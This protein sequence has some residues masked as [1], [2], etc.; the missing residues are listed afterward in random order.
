VRNFTLSGGFEGSGAEVISWRLSHR[1]TAVPALG[2]DLDD[3]AL[4]L[5][6]LGGE[7]CIALFWRA[8]HRRVGLLKTLNLSRGVGVAPFVNDGGTLHR[9]VATRV[10]IDYR[11]RRSTRPFD[12]PDL[13][14]V[15]TRNPN[16]LSIH[17][18]SSHNGGLRPTRAVNGRGNGGGVL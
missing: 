9:H 2:R 15:A 12:I 17:T 18:T 3:G 13:D 8:A 7:L 10:E 6:H 4:L 11:H 5:G 1:Q 16:D 14:R